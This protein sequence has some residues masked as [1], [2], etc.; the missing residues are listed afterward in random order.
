M[1]AMIRD[2]ARS[3][4][5]Q[6]SEPRSLQIIRLELQIS[7]ASPLPWLA[8]QKDDCRVYW[9][10][11]DRTFEMAGVGMADL[12]TIDTS[13]DHDLIFSRLRG[14]MPDNGN[15]VRYYGGLRFNHQSVSGSDAAWK[16]FGCCRFILPRFELCRRPGATYFVCNLAPKNNYGGLAAVLKGLD[17]ITFSIDDIE[18]PMPSIEARQDIPD[19]QGWNSVVGTAMQAIA[20]GELE[21]IVLARRTTIEFSGAIDPVR[22][23]ARLK[24]RSDGCFHFCIQVAP[25]SAF[26]GASPELLYMRLGRTIQTEAVAGTRSRGDTPEADKRLGQELMACEKDLKEHAY[27]ARSIESVLGELCRSRTNSDLPAWAQGGKKPAGLLRLMG[28]QHI[29]SSFQGELAD[30]ITDSDVLRSL[31]PTPS[32]AGCPA[33]KA[34]AMIEELESFDRGWYAGPVG[35]VGLD[36]AEFVVGIRSGLVNGSTLHL[37]SGAGILGA[38]TPQSEWEEIEEKLSNFIQA[39]C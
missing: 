26:V 39:L 8:A 32:V 4:P 15:A 19:L 9:S 29:A 13:F 22:L 18:Q 33:K 21:K 11:R 25:A 12:V 6:A 30:G 5:D 3:H 17:D 36:A 14:R 23:L 7:G 10:D 24:Q 2:A 27:V 35:W 31:H 20:R 1:A 16:E 37:F 38:S 28:V 34:I